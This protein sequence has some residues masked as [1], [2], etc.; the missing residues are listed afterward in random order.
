MSNRYLIV[1][2]DAL[3]AQRPC[4]VRGSHIPGGTEEP[5]R[6]PVLTAH[7]NSALTYDDIPSALAAIKAT[8]WDPKNFSIFP[9]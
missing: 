9:V 4:Y 3:D 8:G 2:A 6:L 5:I 1:D 7:R